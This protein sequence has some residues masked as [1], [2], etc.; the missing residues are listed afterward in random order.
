[1]RSLLPKDLPWDKR[2]INRA[3]FCSSQRG[4]YAVELKLKKDQRNK[5]VDAMWVCIMGSYRKYFYFSHCL[6]PAVSSE[7]FRVIHVKMQQHT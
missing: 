3:E 5:I 2:N 1:M 7:C 6:G 4:E